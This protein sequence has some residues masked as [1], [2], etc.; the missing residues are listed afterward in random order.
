MEKDSIPASYASVAFIYLYSG[1][2]NLGWT[3]AMLDSTL[4]LLIIGAN[5]ANRMVYVVEILP[6]A[7]RAKGVK[8]QVPSTRST[9]S[10]IGIALFW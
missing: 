6:Y 10:G 5:C 7:I 1:V 9:N 8:F 4:S 2:H 3:G